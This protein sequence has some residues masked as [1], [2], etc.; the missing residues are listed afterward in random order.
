MLRDLRATLGVTQAEAAN[1]A[2]ISQ[3]VWSTYENGVRR[4]SLDKLSEIVDR[5]GMRLETRIVPKSPSSTDR[6]GLS[7]SPEFIAVLEFGETLPR[8]EPKPL[9][10][11]SPLWREARARRA[12][13][14]AATTER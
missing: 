3:S 6:A 13:A 9:H 5:L 11:I 7:V 2:G 10:D 4:P 12:A 1:R 14:A 8:K